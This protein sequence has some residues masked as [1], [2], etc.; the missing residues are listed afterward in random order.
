M[1]DR[2][3]SAEREVLSNRPESR[4]VVFL[5]SREAAPATLNLPDHLA[6][7]P[8]FAFVRTSLLYDTPVSGEGVATRTTQRSRSSVLKRSSLPLIW[9]GASRRVPAV[10]AGDTES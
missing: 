9:P 2:E 4:D 6:S 5:A 10:L 1:I 7:V 3:R 8:V